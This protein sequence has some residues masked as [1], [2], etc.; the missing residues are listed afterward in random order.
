MI[1]LSAFAS[2]STCADFGLMVSLRAEGQKCR[3][4]PWCHVACQFIGAPPRSSYQP[5]CTMRGPLTF[6]LLNVL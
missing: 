6:A 1:R 2:L 4:H 5:A 3:W